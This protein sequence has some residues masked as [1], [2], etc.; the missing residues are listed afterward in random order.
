[1][2]SLFSWRMLITI[3][4]LLILG[5]EKKTLLTEPSTTDQEFQESLQ[6]TDVFKENF[7]EPVEFT[8]FF[9]CAGEEIHFSGSF[10]WNYHT[11][12]KANGDFHSVFVANDHSLSGV[13]LSTGTKYHEVG[14]TVEVFSFKGGAPFEYNFAITFD[15]IGQGP[16][17]NVIIKEN[18]HLT[19][20]AN[21]ITTVSFDKFTQECK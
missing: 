4:G 18:V 1:M 11:V 2:K 3:C 14:A 17:N 10:H 15:F 6:N 7:H 13:G 21:G 16:G 9:N 12:L 20:N 8:D 5:C 19:I